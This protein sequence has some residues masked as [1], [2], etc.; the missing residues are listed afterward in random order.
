[1][2]TWHEKA[3]GLPGQLISHRFAR[4]LAAGGFAAVVNISARALLSPYVSFRWAV[5]LSYLIGMV[6]AWTLARL[7]VFD[8]T[9]RQWHHELLRFALV[10]L[11][12][13]AQVWVVSVGLAEWLF[14]RI[15][16]DF[17]PDLTAHVIG[18]CVPAVSSY[19]GHRYFTFARLNS[20]GRPE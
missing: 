16:Y 10:N 11:A 2:K 3:R 4:F 13:A 19:F 14:P 18:V 17:Y 12:G 9:L 6:T 20:R 1:M 8:R 15:G 7:F 5:I